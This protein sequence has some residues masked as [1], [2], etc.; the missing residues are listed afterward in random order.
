[1][2][3]L[4]RLIDSVS[5]FSGKVMRWACACL[6]GVLVYEV[7]ARYVFNAPTI[8]AHVMSCM[9][10]AAMIALGCAYTLLHQGHVRVDVFYSH[11][12][13]RKQAAIDVAGALVFFFPLLIILTYSSARR[14]MYSWSMGEIMTQ[15]YWYP[16]AGPIRTVVFIGL[17]LFLIQGVAEFV[18]NLYMLIRAKRFD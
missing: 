2:R 10:G 16:P 13:P 15:T 17:L 8:W 1:M 12:L 4:V 9:L 7:T 18:R 14:M 5:E 3:I 6:V 11:L